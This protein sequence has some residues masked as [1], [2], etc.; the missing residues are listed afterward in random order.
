MMRTDGTVTTAT[1]GDYF[2]YPDPLPGDD[3]GFSTSLT[4]A[5]DATIQADYTLV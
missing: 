5:T 3:Q 2:L 1:A 4:T